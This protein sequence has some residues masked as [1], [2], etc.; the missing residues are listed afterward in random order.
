MPFYSSSVKVRK[1]KD[2]DQMSDLKGSQKISFFHSMN[3]KLML[4]AIAVALIPLIAFSVFLYQVNR[5]TI[6]ERDKR[7]FN[8]LSV[9]VNNLMVNWLQSHVNYIDFLAQ[10]PDVR[11]MQPD[12]IHE[13]MAKKTAQNKVYE[14]FFVAN[15]TGAVIYMADDKNGI[16]DST[17]NLTDRAYFQNAQNGKKSVSDPVFSK[18]TGNLI[19]VIASPIMSPEGKFQGV[20]GG[21]VPLADLGKVLKDAWLEETG[22]AYL[23]NQAGFFITPSRFANDLKKAGKIKERAELE[24]MISSEPITAA[25]SGKKMIGEFT[26]YRGS[27]VIGSYERLDFPGVNWVIVIEQERAE[28]LADLENIQRFLILGVLIIA[29]IVAA[30]AFAV[31]RSMMRPILAVR[32]ASLQLSMGDPDIQLDITGKDE[33]ASMAAAFQQ[34]VA[35][36]REMVK[37]A[38]QLAKGDLSIQVKPVSPKD[39]LGHAFQEMI[40]SLRQLVREITDNST[41]LQSASQQL[42][43]ATNE[44]GQATTQISMT[45]QQVAKGASQQSASITS[46]ASSVEQLIR[47]INGVAKGA[48]EQAA[49]VENVAQ[50]TN[51]LSAAIRQVS[52]NAKIQSQISAD[53]VQ[54]SQTSAK[55]VDQTVAGMQAIKTRVGYSAEKVR[56]MGERSEQIG[57]IVET[58][59]EIASQT[60]LLAL[61]AAIEAARAGEHGKGFAVVADEVRK[62][63]ER[64]AASTK[65][66]ASLISGIQST[67]NQAVLAMSESAGEVENGVSLANQSSQALKSITQAAEK[68]KQL[69]DEIAVEAEKMSRYSDS[70]VNAMDTVSAVVEENSAATEQMTASSGEVSNAVESIA[71]V[72]EENSAAV[73]E[74]SA[75]TEEM[76]AQIEEVSASTA[77]LAQMAKNLQQIIM[78]FKLN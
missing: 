17:I 24:L 43:I 26:N 63:A 66:I 6:V 48:Q 75:S 21:T 42:S 68:G 60:N 9:Q 51:Q 78:R 57:Q 37:A 5:T 40:A 32:Q 18:D 20:V 25:L 38:E 31:S 19:I 71:S 11:S 39:Q 15:S 30:S 14:T 52:N 27:Q 22:E 61:N 3:G 56:E 69:G 2:S 50:I 62:L 67:V 41:S 70:L 33:I 47:A 45:I 54:A 29:V 1:C 13:V 7:T 59:E 53:T 77:E 12:R 49:A 73:E 46:T 16:R 58:I 72:S 34:L 23:V 28:A 55:I 10:T 65:E 74:V 8:N 4:F 36:L 44:A 76:S 64:S 35:Y